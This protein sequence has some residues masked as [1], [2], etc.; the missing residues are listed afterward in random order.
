MVATVGEN[1]Q[2]RKAVAI[3]VDDAG[4]I[5][6]YMH[7]PMGEGVGKLGALVALSLRSGSMDKSDALREAATK[8][9]MHVAA[10]SPQVFPRLLSLNPVGSRV[11]RPL[12]AP[13][14]CALCPEAT[15]AQAPDAG[16]DLAGQDLLPNSDLG[17]PGTFARIETLN[18]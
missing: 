12:P 5:G 2:L 8:V 1:C 3:S 10:A 17:V 13:V 11:K 4:V 14:P 7:T 15:E 9:A 18:P 6:S 16:L